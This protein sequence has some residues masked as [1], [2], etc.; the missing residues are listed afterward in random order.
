M[1]TQATHGVMVLGLITEGACARYRILRA[2]E[3]LF[4][5]SNLLTA[6]KHGGD[7]WRQCPVTAVLDTSLNRV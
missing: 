1:P 5:E 2:E 3:K 7:I 4:Q 6:V